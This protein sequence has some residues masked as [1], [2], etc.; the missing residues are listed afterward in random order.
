[1]SLKLASREYFLE[2]QSIADDIAKEC[3]EESDGDRSDAEDLVHD[4]LH[5]AIDG[6]ELVIYYAGNDT[7]LDHTDHDTAWEDCYSSEDIGEL[8]KEKG[9][10]GAR[11]VQAFFAMEA[12]VRDL[13]DGA[14]DEAETAWESAKAAE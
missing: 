14:L 8:V 5:E 2:C 11:T 9:M 10:D 1:M 7:I 6:H 3:I 4:K 12:D 13:I